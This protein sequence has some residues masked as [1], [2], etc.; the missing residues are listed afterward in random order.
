MAINATNIGVDITPEGHELYPHGTTEFPLACYDMEFDRDG[1]PWHWHDEW[2]MVYIPEGQLEFT[3]GAKKYTIKE[4]EGILINGGILHAGAGCAGV[5][6]HLRSLVFHPRLIGGSVDSVYWQKYVEPLIRNRNFREIY[7]NGSEAWHGQILTLLR[8]A[9]EYCA[10]DEEGYEIYVR[11]KLSRLALL[12][13]EHVSS[14]QEKI[15]EKTLR[16]T[17]RVKQMIQYIN[18]HYR[19]DFTVRNMAEY[20]GVSESECLRCFR[21]IVGM[22]PVKYVRQYRLQI[23]AELLMTTDLKITEIA[24]KCGFS[25]SSYFTKSFR[26]W[27]GIAPGEYRKVSV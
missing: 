2:E 3:V 25:D 17:L 14:A 21:N 22:P 23:A 4:G 12:L 15:S 13:R 24:E 10:G 16:N 27:R 7:L 9:W 1:F 11:E 26:E 18:E 20:A 6:S 5:P 19:E 8:E